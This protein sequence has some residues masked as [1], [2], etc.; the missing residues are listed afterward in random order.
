MRY[1]RAIKESVIRKVLPP[2]GRSIRS[3]GKEYG[4]SE[5]TIRNWI[6]QA[7]PDTL[8]VGDGE[9]GP[10]HMGFAEKYRLVPEAAGIPEEQK[11][12]WIREKGLHTEHLTLWEQEIQEIVTDRH[13]DK[14]EE[15]ATA[16]KRIKEL[17]K[18]LNRKDKALAEMAALIALKKKIRSILEDPEDD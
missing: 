9:L 17:E 10:R 5:Q 7:N 4:I 8:T 16:K 11:G 15:L 6:D 2:E 18:E 13:Q 3:I 1:S 14:R 12:S